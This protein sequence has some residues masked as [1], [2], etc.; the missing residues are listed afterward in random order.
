MGPDVILGCNSYNWFIWS[1][2]VYWRANSNMA[3]GLLNPKW[4]DAMAAQ[5]SGGAYEISQRFTALLGWG[6]T[7]GFADDWAYEGAYERYVADEAMAARLR[8]S[9][10]EAQR[11]MLRRLLEAHGRGLWSTAAAEQ[12][13]RLRELYQE[14]EDVL[15]LGVKNSGDSTASKT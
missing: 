13:D 12:L 1:Y 4:A 15:E 5:G 14:A 10:P 11:N 6:A 2:S 9:N 8:A 7:A 3:F